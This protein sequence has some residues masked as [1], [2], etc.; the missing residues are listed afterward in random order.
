MQF[1]GVQAAYAPGNLNTSRRSKLPLS[2]TPVLTTQYAM[3]EYGQY[4]HIHTWA[5]VS[6]LV[7]LM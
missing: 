6:G 3:W 4:L 2:L 5:K 7:E 1:V